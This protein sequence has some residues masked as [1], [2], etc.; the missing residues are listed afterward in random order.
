ML[1]D[2][3]ADRWRCS[4]AFERTLDQRGSGGG[5]R[6]AIRGQLPELADKQLGI[7][8][9]EQAVSVSARNPD[10]SHGTECSSAERPFLRSGEAR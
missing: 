6:I 5:P 9:G 8:R 3:D 1:G 7:A 4:V 10:G 2:V